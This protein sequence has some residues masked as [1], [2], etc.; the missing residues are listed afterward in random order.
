MRASGQVSVMVDLDSSSTPP[1]CAPYCLTM[2][3]L[4]RNNLGREADGVA[5]ACVQQPAARV[6]SHVKASPT[7]AGIRGHIWTADEAKPTHSAIKACVQY[8]VIGNQVV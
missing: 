1:G 7:K 2:R 5:S 3:D 6:R 8:V 4:M